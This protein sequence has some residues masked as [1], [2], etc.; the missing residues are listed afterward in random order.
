LASWRADGL[1]LALFLALAVFQ[2]G[3][4]FDAGRALFVGPDPVNDCWSL[5]WV[6]ANLVERPRELWE[7]NN[8]FPSRDAVLFSEPYLGPAVLV[9]PLRLFTKNPVLL[10]NAAVLLVLVLASCGCFLR[11]AALRGLAAP[12]GSSCR[13]AR[14]RASTH[15]LNISRSGFPFLMLGCCGSP[16]AR[17][18][19]RTSPRWPSPRGGNQRLPR[20][21][22]GLSLPAGGGMGWR[23]LA[24]PTLG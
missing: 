14:T 4:G 6:S 23:E 3:I 21:L 2:T 17:P 5:R 9:A 20:L 1:A 22:R 7:A 24:A 10:Y 13:T 18:R 16:T 11:P 15:A 8:F 12:L 19:R